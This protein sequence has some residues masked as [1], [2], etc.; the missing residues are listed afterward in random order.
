MFDIQYSVRACIR[1]TCKLRGFMLW[2]IDIIDVVLPNAVGGFNIQG[3]L[4]WV[5]A[6]IVY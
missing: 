5:Y 1:S 2:Q 4:D 6:Y 3:C